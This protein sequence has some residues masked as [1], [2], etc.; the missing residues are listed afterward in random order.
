V[1]LDVSRRTI[2]A[3]AL[4]AAALG[5]GNYVRTR[6]RRNGDQSRREGF[7]MRSLNVVNE[8]DEAVQVALRVT[9]EGDESEE[10]SDKTVELTP[11][12][13]GSGVDDDRAHVNGVWI[14]SADEYHIRAERGNERLDLSAA[15]IESRLDGSG[16]DGECADVTIVVGEDGGLSSRVAPSDAC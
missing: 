9:V 7:R 5:G 12:G 4:G 10:V 11:A 3:G 1:T 6:Y 8:S 15:E 13:T 2:L 14:K 16:W